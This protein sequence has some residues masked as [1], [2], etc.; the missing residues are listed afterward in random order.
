MR[1]YHIYRFRARINRKKCIRLVRFNLFQLQFSQHYSG[2]FNF[3]RYIPHRIYILSLTKNIVFSFFWH[4]YRFPFQLLNSKV[5][6]D[7]CIAFWRWQVSVFAT[8][9]WLPHCAREFHRSSCVRSKS[10]SGKRFPCLW[11]V[12]R[13]YS[14]VIDL[15]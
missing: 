1:S 11:A 14:R 7:T 9:Q 5:P 8:R 3:F 15:T 12:Q 4:L 2:N 13:N 6:S 10:N